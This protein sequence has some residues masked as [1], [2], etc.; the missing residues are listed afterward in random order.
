MKR[1]QRWTL[2]LVVGLT[3]GASATW[4]WS[5]GPYQFT[6]NSI[7][8]TQDSAYD[9][10]IAAVNRFRNAYFSGTVTAGTFSGAVS[11]SSGT[12]TSGITVGTSG[13]QVTQVRIYSQILG[14]VAMAALSPSG[15]LTS[16]TQGFT[17]DGLTQAD[18]VFINGPAPTALCPPNGAVFVSNA[19]TLA[20]GFNQLTS[21]LCTPA[22]GTYK[23][24]AIRS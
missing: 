5:Q 23:I 15:T 9:L 7:A 6:P 20:I 24:T 3:L 2:S 14:P 19:S 16:A 11:T 8:P 13:T 21:D 18:K 17:V 12:F 22:T 10:G 1:W 4:V